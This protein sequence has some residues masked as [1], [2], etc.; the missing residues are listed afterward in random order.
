M[1]YQKWHFTFMSN[2]PINTA[3]PAEEGIS[4]I[5]ILRFLKDAYKTILVFSILGIVAAFAYL[6]IAPKQFEARAQIK[7]AQFGSSNNNI[8]PQGVNVEEPAHLVARLSYPNSYTPKTLMACG[9]QDQAN[10][11]LVL[12]TIKVTIP[13]AVTNIVEIKTFGG[14]QQAV[15]DCALAVFDQIKTSQAQIVATY[16]EQFKIKLAYAEGRLAKVEQLFTKAEK[17]GSANLV[18]YL[19]M[20]EEIR[21]QLSEISTI[22]NILESNKNQ[23]TNL[24][25][26]VYASDIPIAPKKRKILAVGLFCGFFL[27]LLIALARQ[28]ITNFKIQAGGTL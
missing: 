9:L 22:K 16:I 18:A 17:S 8:S 10:P 15:Q 26:P 19:Y 20:Q 2:S 23:I 13:K 27:G 7:M 11:A 25:A 1:L 3:L 4:L 6:A 12:S 28:M 21:Q 5:D 24:I 14:S